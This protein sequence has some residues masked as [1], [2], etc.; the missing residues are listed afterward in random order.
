[1]SNGFALVIPDEMIKKITEADT[2]I[3]TLAKTSQEARDTIVTA[4]Q[5]MATQGVDAFI[6]RLDE[7][8]RRIKE[9]AREASGSVTI[10][11]DSNDNEVLNAANSIAGLAQNL[12][13]LNAVYQAITTEQKGGR[14]YVSTIGRDVA[15]KSYRR[16]DTVRKQMERS[17]AELTRAE[18]DYAR[19]LDMTNAKIEAVRQAQEEYNRAA[20]E[21]AQNKIGELSGFDIKTSTLNELKSRAEE[22]K[23]VLANLE[24]D[25]DQWEQLNRVLQNTKKRIKELEGKLNDADKKTKM[26]AESM[27]LVGQITATFLGINAIAKFVNKLKDVRAEF[28]FQNR[29]LQILLQNRQEADI[30]WD[31]TVALAVNSPFRVQ[32]LVSYTKQLAAYRVESEKLYDTTKMLADISSGLGVDM[33]RLILA[34]GQVKAANYLRGTELRQF[35][36]A[37]I[38]ILGELSEY[39]TKLEGH[40]VSVAEV[41]ERVSRRMVLFEDVD[42]VLKNITS[43]GGTFYKMQE[44]Q[45]KT[46]R[47]QIMNLQ[48]SIDVMLNEIGEST[49]GALKGGVRAVR[50]L[51]EEWETLSYVL[52]SVV[53]IFSGLSVTVLIAAKNLGF[54]TTATLKETAALGGLSGALARTILSLKQFAAAAKTSGGI[55]GMAIGLIV[56]TLGILI[57]RMSRANKEMERHQALLKTQVGETGRL[58]DKI[59]ELSTR[60]NELYEANKKLDEASE[61]YRENQEEIMSIEEKRKKILK[62]LAITDESYAKQLRSQMNDVEKLKELMED[63]NEQ[64]R[65]RT[66]LELGLSKIGLK[67]LS[68]DYDT[69]SDTKE[70]EE[71]NLLTEYQRVLAQVEYALK[72]S[73]IAEQEREILEEF[74]NSEEDVVTRLINLNLRIKKYSKVFGEALSPSMLAIEGLISDRSI[75]I[76]NRMTKQMEEMQIT[77]AGALEEYIGFFKSMDENQDDIANSLNFDIPKEQR[78]EARNNIYEY[79]EDVLDANGFVGKL[80]EQSREIFEKAFGF[81]W[82]SYT[83]KDLAEWQDLYNH[84]LQSLSG[85]KPDEIQNAEQTIESQRELLDREIAQLTENIEREETAD[86]AIKQARKQEIQRMKELLANSIAARNYLGQ[87]IEDDDDSKSMLEKRIRVIK[88]INEAYKELSKTFD[89]AKAKQGALDKFGSAF[90][91]AWGR[92]V[93]DMGFDLFTESGVTEAFNKVVEEAKDATE[94][95]QAQLAQGEYVLELEVTTKQTNDEKIKREIEEQFSNYELSLELDELGL[96]RDLMNKIFGFE[97]IDLSGL[98]KVLEERKGEFIGTEMD[99]SY[100]DF[101]DKISKLEEDKRNKDLKKYSQYIIKGRQERVKIKMEEVKQL[102]EIEDAFRGKNLEKEKQ[103][104]QE[105]V[106]EETKSKLQKL[107]WEEFEKSDSYLA[108]FDNLDHVST[109]A[110]RNMVDRLNEL[111]SSLSDLPASDLKAIINAMEKLEKELVERNPLANF[112]SNF[113]EAISYLTQRNKLEKEY[114]EINPRKMDLESQKNFLEKQIG[115]ATQRYEQLAKEDANSLNTQ[116]ALENLQQLQKEYDGILDALYLINPKWQRIVD[117]MNEGQEAASNVGKGFERVSE[118]MSHVNDAITKV[119]ENFTNVFG[120]MSDK[121]RDTLDTMSALLEDTSNIGSAIGKLIATEGADI[122]SWAKLVEGISSFVGNIFA[123]GDKKKERSIQAQVAL[124]EELNKQY[125]RLD[126][127]TDKI[128]SNDAYVANYNTMQ[129]LLDKQIASIRKQIDLEESK[130]KSDDARI[131]QLTEQE[132]ELQKAKS[133]L[134]QEALEWQGGIANSNYLSMADDIFSSMYDSFKETGNALSGLETSFDDFFE[135]LAKRQAMLRMSDVFAKQF[136]EINKMF[137]KDSDGGMTA[138]PEEISAA[139]KALEEK[140]P[141]L[142]RFFDTIMETYGISSEAGGQLSTLQGAIS[143]IREEQADIIASYLNSLRAILVEKKDDISKFINSFDIVGQ[144]TTPLLEEL[145]V[146]TAQ[147]RDISELLASIRWTSSGSGVGLNVHIIE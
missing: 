41:F 55:W 16:L 46:L 38:N 67:Q 78:D 101:L 73:T 141:E 3:K 30:L 88:E 45:A 96:P 43:E 29:S 130:R 10:K 76:I 66:M 35:S 6:A 103:A 37:G 68:E 54:F 18:Q 137:D 42:A 74:M 63:Y 135:N 128:Y 114:A 143:G 110:I 80:R 28:E 59:L 111:K 97:S 50:F 140:M 142:K 82:K 65:V 20:R 60:M 7:A 1:M 72:N 62:D 86:E 52:T 92:T 146:Q 104:A 33:Q 2:K 132:E 47:G 70:R 139:K 17:L 99:E 112:G 134:A 95:T 126:E 27:Q 108:I 79:F 24:P 115:E 4:F 147:I 23:T 90:L 133:E 119:F 122:S 64:I 56:T 32:Q 12:E 131:K 106:K 8:N 109:M 93:E 36:E 87:G 124:V 49:E 116:K 138:T 11:I 15:N 113:K 123:I 40:A 91:S 107:D 14:I 105:A 85:D 34:Y 121:M 81:E 98:K 26:L 125:E 25:T 144:V 75:R 39:F 71:V 117:S 51:V 84:F 145:R 44:E 69:K 102:Q 129:E 48:D 31:K 57:P 136:D 120:N 118:D 13:R 9:L 53:G 19:V 22:I 83:Q 100:Q 127:L 94:R 58:A 61:A 21:A 89:D 77:S 5:E